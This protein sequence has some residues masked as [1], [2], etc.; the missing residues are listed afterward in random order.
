MRRNTITIIELIIILCVIVAVVRIRSCKMPESELSYTGK[1]LG[2]AHE[3]THIIDDYFGL[4]DKIRNREI[5][6]EEANYDLQKIKTSFI[7][8][9][10]KIETIIPPRNY[11]NEHEDFI[12]AFQCCIDS[13]DISLYTINTKD[14]KI[15]ETTVKEAK[16][17]IKEYERYTYKYTHSMCHDLR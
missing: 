17:K 11:G 8:K 9:K 7:D 1:M 16:D 5:T 10:R 2:A 3:Q 14:E 15:K 6:V 4:I 13:V 12:K